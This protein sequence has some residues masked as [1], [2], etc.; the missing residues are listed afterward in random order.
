MKYS[1]SSIVVA[2][3]LVAGAAHAKSVGRGP[4]AS[5]GADRLAACHSYTAGT[6]AATKARNASGTVA[7]SDPKCNL[8]HDRVTPLTIAQVA[9]RT[10]Y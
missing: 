7:A 3:A 5:D 9:D 6:G 10:A 1:L 8:C 4:G 2:A